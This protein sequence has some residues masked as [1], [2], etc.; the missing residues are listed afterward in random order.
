M[1]EYLKMET[2]PERRMYLD[3]LLD[4]Y[5]SVREAAVL[6]DGRIDTLRQ[7][8]VVAFGIVLAFFGTIGLDSAPWLL[9]A[10]SM[11]FSVFGL[12]LGYAARQIRLLARYEAWV[13]RP[14]FERF[15]RTE[16]ED[17][18]IAV[19]EWQAFY[20]KELFGGNWFKRLISGLQGISTVLFPVGASSGS[21][22]V[23]VVTLWLQ[24][25]TAS[26]IEVILL[27]TSILLWILMMICFIPETSTTSYVA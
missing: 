26:T 1:D 12:L 19:L 5:K 8:T 27:P 20:R 24:G 7:T 11:V 2:R 16:M 13:L 6:I 14:K 25:P 4:E 18:S 3:V 23:Y 10:A 15:L 9:L 17:S 22:A 21:I